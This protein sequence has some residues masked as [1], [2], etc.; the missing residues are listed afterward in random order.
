MKF[1]AHFEAIHSSF[2]EFEDD[3]G[4]YDSPEEGKD[5]VRN[6]ER[7]HIM[8]ITTTTHCLLLQFVEF[9]IGRHKTTL[10]SA[11]TSIS[12]CK[13]MTSSRTTIGASSSENQ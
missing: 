13:M 12:H 5:C 9:T 8:L 7:R 2:E 3:V 10:L 11:Q 6:V 4:R 1:G